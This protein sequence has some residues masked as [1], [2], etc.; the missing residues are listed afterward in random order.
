[1]APKT[2]YAGGTSMWMQKNNVKMHLH[3]M[4]QS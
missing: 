3:K 1:V 2:Q 4:T